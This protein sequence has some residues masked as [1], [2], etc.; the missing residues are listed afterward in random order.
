MQLRTP[1]PSSSFET[2]IEDLFGKTEEPSAAP[3]PSHLFSINS[4][5][6]AWEL[7]ANSRASPPRYRE[8]PSSRVAAYGYD[9]AQATHEISLDP[10]R[11]LSE[12]GLY[13]GASEADVAAL[14][15]EFALRNNPDRVPPELRELATNRM[16]I[17]NDLVDRYVARLRNAGR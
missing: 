5:E 15:R 10:E 6:A 11:I 3:K 17:A 9:R 12:L 8:N 1:P 16:M 14:R 4:L 2:L 13:A 7:A